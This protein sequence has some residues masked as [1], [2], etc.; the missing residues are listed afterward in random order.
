MKSKKPKRGNLSKVKPH[1][2]PPGARRESWTITK[3]DLAHLVR[4]QLVH[5]LGGTDKDPG[6]REPNWDRWS[7]VKSVEPWQ[8][9]MLAVDADPDDPR[10][11]KARGVTLPWLSLE[12]LAGHAQLK[13]EHVI[14]SREE[15]ERTAPLRDFGARLLRLRWKHLPDLYPQP[16][17]DPPDWGEWGQMAK[18]TLWQVIALSLNISP[19]FLMD[20]EPFSLGLAKR[21]QFPDDFFMRL[22]ISDSHL[23]D[24]DDGLPTLREPGNQNCEKYGAWVRLKQFAA[25]AQRP[26]RHWTLP[27]EFPRP[28]ATTQVSSGKIEEMAGTPSMSGESGKAFDVAAPATRKADAEGP[29]PA[30][31]EASQITKPTRP[32]PQNGHLL[33]APNSEPAP[34]PDP[35]PS[36]SSSTGQ[37]AESGDEGKPLAKVRYRNLLKMIAALV[38]MEGLENPANTAEDVDRLIKGRRLNGPA[39]ETTSDFLRLALTLITSKDERKVKLGERPAGGHN[40]LVI[41]GVKVW[42]KRFH[43]FLQTAGEI[44]EHLN[45]MGVTTGPKIGILQKN[46]KDAAIVIGVPAK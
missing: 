1:Q 9:L 39:P 44:A 11:A 38:G 33:L 21:L 15:Y 37:T 42:Q 36:N 14:F 3:V 41:I 16:R 45:A 4:D 6:F 34:S 2:V 23:D 31:A 26:I 20:D 17:T 10:L 13:P 43:S 12:H 18:A 24:P 25:F 28:A 5:L 46:L 30:A 29:A 22:R 7:R 8:A 19:K 40:L 32:E 35:R 27:S